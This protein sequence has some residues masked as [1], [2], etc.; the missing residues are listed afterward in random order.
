MGDVGMTSALTEMGTNDVSRWA[1]GNQLSCFLIKGGIENGQ[2]FADVKC[3][4]P[5][6][7]SSTG[8][9]RHEHCRV[10]VQASVFVPV[11]EK[12]QL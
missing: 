3:A 9:N 10:Q 12:Q 1:A 5:P 8:S 7:K 11:L 2:K 4:R 6:S